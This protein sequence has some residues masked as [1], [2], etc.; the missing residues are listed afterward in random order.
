MANM[1]A[2]QVERLLKQSK[3][4]YIHHYITESTV[5]NESGDDIGRLSNKVLKNMLLKGKV[6]QVGTSNEF[7]SNGYFQLCDGK[8]EV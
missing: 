5:R 7:W 6:K 2:Q 8:E 3:D 1:T 4:Y